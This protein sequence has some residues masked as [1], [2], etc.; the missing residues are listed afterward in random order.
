MVLTV[1]YH[2]HERSIKMKHRLFLAL[3]LLAV[4]IS[5]G[6]FAATL[7][8]TESSSTQIV[9]TSPGTEVSGLGHIG[10]QGAFTEYWGLS[11]DATTAV[12]TITTENPDVNMNLSSVKVS[13]GTTDWFAVFDGTGEWTVS[14]AI[15]ALVNYTIEVIGTGTLAATYAINVSAVPLPAALWLFGSALVGLGFLT[16]RGN[17]GSAIM[18]A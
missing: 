1:R 6:A 12:V 2:T 10:A 16:R 11:S 17:T 15:A 14:L 8:L 7:T 9:L 3:A 5:H 13:D 18:A 4:F